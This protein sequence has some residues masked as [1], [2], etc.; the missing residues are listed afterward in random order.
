MKTG[1]A[2][3]IIWSLEQAGARNKALEE[4]KKWLEGKIGC[5]PIDAEDDDETK[6]L[7]QR[8]NLAWLAL[9]RIPNLDTTTSIV[10]LPPYERLLT[11]ELELSKKVP[12]DLVENL[13]S[14]L[15]LIK[16]IEHRLLSDFEEGKR[17]HTELIRV[18][19]FRA[20]LELQILSAKR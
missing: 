19:F 4:R 1:F 6:L 10:W 12:L 18:R 17:N 11:A 20:T 16:G 13:E 7:K 8:A 14:I 15:V 5:Y 9:E 2:P 3:I